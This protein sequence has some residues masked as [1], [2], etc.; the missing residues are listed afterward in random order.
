MARFSFI[1]ESEHRTLGGVKLNKSTHTSMI[2]RHITYIHDCFISNGMDAKG[3][4][5]KSSHLPF[6]CS[7]THTLISY[8]Y[9]ITYIHIYIY[10]YVCMLCMYVCIIYICMYFCSPLPPILHSR[11]E[12]PSIPCETSDLR[13]YSV[14]VCV[15]RVSVS[16]C[17]P[18]GYCF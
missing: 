8:T 4:R 10:T 13:Y 3:T 16:M 11:R 5:F 1:R 17:L 14:F 15:K 6:L 2:S 9:I 18:F 7:Y 12:A